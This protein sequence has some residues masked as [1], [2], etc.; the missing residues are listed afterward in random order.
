MFSQRQKRQRL[1]I[2]AQ[3]AHLKV[4]QAPFGAFFIIRPYIT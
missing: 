3:K 1:K 2:Q 4:L